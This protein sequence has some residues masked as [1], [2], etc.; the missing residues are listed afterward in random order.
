ME[1]ACKPTQR[2][3]VLL[4]VKVG[5]KI[6][7]KGYVGGRGLAFW[8]T[9]ERA[10]EGCD[11]YACTS[12]MGGRD[13]FSGV[14]VVL[15]T[16]DPASNRMMPLIYAVEND[17]HPRGGLSIYPTLA[18][19]QCFFDYHN[20]PVPFLLRI[21]H[22]NRSLIVDYDL[23]HLPGTHF[24]HCMTIRDIDLP[25]NYF[26][27]ISAMTSEIYAD[28]MDV[29]L[30]EVSELNAQPSKQ[31]PLRPHELEK[32][33][34]GEGLNVTESQEW[35]EEAERLASEV[36]G[37]QNPDGA[38]GEAYNVMLTPEYL[39]TLRETQYKILESLD[40]LHASNFGGSTSNSDSQPA[41]NENLHQVVG[42]IQHISSKVDA[43]SKAASQVELLVQKANGLE[44]TVKQLQATI[45]TNHDKSAAKFDSLESKVNELK[46]QAANEPVLNKPQAS[47]PS[48]PDQTVTHT[49]MII[50]IFLAT[51]GVLL[52]LYAVWAS[53]KQSSQAKKFI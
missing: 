14:A 46:V 15:D 6:S 2:V 35:I 12:F 48:A 37:E 39:E 50:L 10:N 41:G 36:E 34:Q 20:R 44:Q 16:T 8:Y 3:G 49:Y 9:K 17:G 32:Q 52:G 19:S 30:V 21:Q 23:S 29:T 11:S 22:V 51:L 25:T 18:R 5:L 45:N 24:N 27:G 28:D 1:Q 38:Y 40:H 33:E 43:L 7:S 4:K 13:G 42:M 53:R 47:H 26:F 31:H